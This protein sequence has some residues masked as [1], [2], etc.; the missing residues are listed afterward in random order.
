MVIC[1]YSELA[2]CFDQ[3]IF[4]VKLSETS[5]IPSAPV[6]PTN[7]SRT[8]LLKAIVS[9]LAIWLVVRYWKLFYIQV[10]VLNS[11]EQNQ[12]WTYSPKNDFLTALYR[13]HSILFWKEYH[14]KYTIHQTAFHFS[15]FCPS[16]KACS[17]SGKACGKFSRIRK[18]KKKSF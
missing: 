4:S 1:A 5:D 9:L 14:T 15:I 16:V 18:T 7:L 6:A 10:C 12:F 13:S 3:N 8:A 2:S 11:H 17:G